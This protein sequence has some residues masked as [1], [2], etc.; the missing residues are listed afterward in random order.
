MPR[1][2][3]IVGVEALAR[4]Q[5]PT[6]GVLAPDAFL[7]I[8]EELNVVATIDRMVLEQALASFNDWIGRRPRRAA[9]VGQRLGAPAAGRGA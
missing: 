1:R 9:R 3:E 2:F 6:Q 4:W 7:K 5:H 8:A